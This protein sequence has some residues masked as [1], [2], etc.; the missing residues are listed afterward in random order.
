MAVL[1]L[2]WYQEEAVDA[3]W[4]FI[5]S[6][7]RA[8]YI[9]APCSA[10][11]SLIQASAIQ[12]VL[13]EYPES[14]ILCV[15]HNQDLVGQN[16][17]EFG[18]LCPDIDYGIYC[19]GLSRKELHDI[20][21][22]TVQSLARVKT[23]PEWEIVFV[24]E[25]HLCSKNTKNYM[26]LLKSIWAANP[27]AKLVGLSATP[28]RTDSGDIRSEGIFTNKIYEI[29]I[30]TLLDEGY[31]APIVSRTTTDARID[32]SQIAT[33]R[34]EYENSS[35]AAAF[36][37]ED[38]YKAYMSLIASIYLSGQR[39]KFLIF[40][41]NL[42]HC[43]AMVSTL[44]SLGIPIFYCDGTTAKKERKRIVEDFRECKR[45][46]LINC[47]LYTTG[48][49]VKDI[50]CL[51]MVFATQSA[52]KYCQVIGRLQRIAEG[53]IDGLLLDFGK[54]I[55][56][57]GPIN[58][59]QVEPKFSNK[60]KT[61][62]SVVRACMKCGYYTHIKFKNCGECGEP[63]PIQEREVNK[64][65]TKKASDLSVV[66][67]LNVPKMYDIRGIAYLFVVGRQKKPM[68]KIK[69]LT[70]LNVLEGYL[71]FD[72]TGYALEKAR[73]TWISMRGLQP[74]PKST[75]EAWA[76]RNE[77]QQPV[78]VIAEKK[79]MYTEVTTHYY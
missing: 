8:S 56:R 61:T 7:K 55:E 52:I 17:S 73:A 29:D 18:G 14:K 67:K 44:E 21:F 79:G 10:G 48:F 40:G 16:S 57:F 25:F 50:D 19:A 15:A 28:F 20:T 38:K 13:S 35:M 26:K 34:G 45:G 11:K 22:G 24:D 9:V 58:L 3:I 1:E 12:K 72:H 69:Y 76:R 42:A 78:R 41:V 75:K 30:E 32:M 39:N 59:L 6:D 31:L 49:N 71:C 54:N 5:W 64:S 62:A 33:V 37:S 36:M 53:K 63:F 70:P 4:D 23:L 46:V 2:R 27:N 43:Q 47:G 68:V 51:A 65:L 74:L 66:S 60:N 77:L